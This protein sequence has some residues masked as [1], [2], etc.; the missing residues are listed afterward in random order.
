MYRRRR[1]TKRR[2]LAR[3]LSARRRT[4]G[5]RVGSAR[6]KAVE[7]IVDTGTEKWD[8]RALYYQPMILC[9]Q[10]TIEINDRIR[11]VINVRGVRL[12][13]NLRNELADPLTVNVAVLSI[14]DWYGWDVSGTGP[15][16]ENLFRG[17][18]DQR[19][20]GMTNLLCN[21]EYSHNA[22]NTDLFTV[23]KHKRYLLAPI[24]ENNST[25]KSTKSSYRK[26][27]WYIPLRRQVRF[28]SNTDIEPVNGQLFWVVWCDK[29]LTKSE[30]A[31]TT[32]ALAK[33]VRSILY[34]KD[35]K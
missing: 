35:P 21:L 25:Y 34:F 24:G 9:N 14:K 13:M 16:T 3:S 17:Y 2:R 22:L 30:V 32:D 18:A 15:V 12:Q 33:Q 7:G 19:G 26:L 31:G 28:D 29:F 11:N 27:D 20:V 1:P 6:T 4:I 23:L 5:E 10:G 8:T